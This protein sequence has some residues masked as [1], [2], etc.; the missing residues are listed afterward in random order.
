[1]GGLS[2]SGLADK[3]PF[4]SYTLEDIELIAVAYVA[5]DLETYIK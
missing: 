1:M 5:L 4:H 2:F 3:N